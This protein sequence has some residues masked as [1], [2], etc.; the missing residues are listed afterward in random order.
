MVDNATLAIVFGNDA[1]NAT[2]EITA[3]G[4][5][6]ITLPSPAS[7]NPLLF[8][9]QI[10]P[11]QIFALDLALSLGYNPDKPRNLAKSVTVL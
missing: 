7:D 9:N 4:G 3:R 2:A 1:N 11:A 6:V 10:I 5:K 8:I